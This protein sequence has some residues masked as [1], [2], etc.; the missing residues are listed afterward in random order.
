MEIVQKAKLAMWRINPDHIVSAETVCFKDTDG[1][2]CES[3]RVETRF[4]ETLI[5]L[6][7][8]VNADNPLTADM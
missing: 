3:F 2:N 4:P 6:N 8:L 5:M 1:D 7:R